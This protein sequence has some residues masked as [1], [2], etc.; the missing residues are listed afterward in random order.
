MITDRWCRQYGAVW[1]WYLPLCICIISFYFFFTLFLSSPFV[2]FSLV[3][4]NQMEWSPVPVCPSLMCFFFLTRAIL[5]G[6]TCFDNLCPMSVYVYFVLYV[7]MDGF[8][9]FNL[10]KGLRCEKRCCCF[11]NV[12]LH[13]WQSVVVLKWPSVVDRTLKIWLLTP[14]WS[15][16]SETHDVSINHHLQENNI[17]E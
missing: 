5:K 8:S 7:W 17:R 9:R 13:I 11:F 3:S 2:Y 14:C 6:L 12:N 10:R 1:H 15:Y 16:W 4:I